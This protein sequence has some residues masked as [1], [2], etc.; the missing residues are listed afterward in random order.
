M[1]RSTREQ[2]SMILELTEEGAFQSVTAFPSEVEELPYLM[3]I[4]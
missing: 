1:K 2:E 3:V 4:V